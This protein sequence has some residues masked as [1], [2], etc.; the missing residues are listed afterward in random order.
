MKTSVIPKEITII[1]NRAFCNCAD[2]A[3]IVIPGGV[4]KIGMNAFWNCSN[5][6]SVTIPESVTEISLLA[7]SNCSKLTSITFQGTMA[8]WNAID[9]YSEPAWSWNKDTPITVVHCTDGDVPIE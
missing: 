6:S 2:L 7:F 1:D 5:L 9:K 4:T 8:Q 3:S